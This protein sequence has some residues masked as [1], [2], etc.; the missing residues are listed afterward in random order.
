MTK[1]RTHSGANT[2]APAKGSAKD[3]AKGTVNCYGCQHHFITHDK[4]KPYGCRAFAFKGPM[5]P[6]RTVWNVTGTE[7]AYFKQKSDFAAKWRHRS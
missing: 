2:N 4:N 5:L 1:A 7:C 3:P 6:S